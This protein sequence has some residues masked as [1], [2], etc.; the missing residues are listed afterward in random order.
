MSYEVGALHAEASPQRLGEVGLL[1][2]EIAVA[3]GLVGIPETEKVEHQHPPAR[4]QRVHDLDTV[5]RAGGKAVEE[6]EARSVLV[7]DS[8]REDLE[9]PSVELH[10][11]PLTGIEPVRDARETGHAETLPRQR[12]PPQ[13]RQRS[14]PLGM[15]AAG[16]L[17]HG[18]LGF[19]NSQ[20]PLLC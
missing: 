18:R 14:T 10:S 6:R 19:L 20:D 15:S 17:S 4:A 1:V 7:P 12:P 8:T 3:A 13:N 9:P 16:N 2:D 11:D 5:P